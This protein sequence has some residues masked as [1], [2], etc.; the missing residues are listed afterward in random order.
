M[1]NQT[2]SHIRQERRSG[3]WEAW[4]SDVRCCCCLAGFEYCQI[5]NKHYKHGLSLSLAFWWLWLG[6]VFWIKPKAHTPHPKYSKAQQNVRNAT[7]TTTA[8]YSSTMRDRRRY[9]TN[10]RYSTSTYTQHTQHIHFPIRKQGKSSY[11]HAVH[12]DYARGGT[13]SSTVERD[14]PMCYWAKWYECVCVFV[15]VWL[16]ERVCVCIEGGLN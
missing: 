13:V 15:W 1:E 5:Y 2:A 4:W 12:D 16:D 10:R 11:A 14:Q 6:L 8:L 3:G 9:P 7:R